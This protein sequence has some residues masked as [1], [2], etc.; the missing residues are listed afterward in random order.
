MT[1]HRTVGPRG[2]LGRALLAALLVAA[3]LQAATATSAAARDDAPVLTVDT[4]SYS[5]AEPTPGMP[6][7]Y[8]S[9]VGVGA[10]S[11][12]ENG[13]ANS[14]AVTLTHT[15][16]TGVKP[17]GGNGGPDWQCQAPSGQSITCATVGGSLTADT[18]LPTVAFSG[19][20]TGPGMTASIIQTS[21]S[22]AASSANA[23]P[24]TDTLMTAGTVPAAPS[25]VSTSA[26]G[27]PVDGG[28]PLTVRSDTD[29][30]PTILLIGTTAELAAGAPEFL[31]PCTSGPAAGCF[32]QQDDGSHIES[33]PARSTPGAVEVVVVTLGVGASTSYSYDAIPTP[34][35][36]DP[37]AAAT[38]AD[39]GPLS[40][41]SL[42]VGEEGVRYSITLPPPLGGSPLSWAVSG[43]TLP[44]GL[45]LSTSNGVLSGI[46]TTGGEYTFTVLTTDFGG[47]QET[48]EFGVTIAARPV[49]TFSA[50]DGQQGLNYSE[51]PSVEGGIAP[52][53]W[54][55]VAGALPGNLSVDS[56]TGLISGTPTVSGTFSATVAAVDAL[57]QRGTATFS[58]VIV[59]APMLTFGAPPS[60]RVA[61][62]YS[63]TLTATGT[64]PLVWSI[65]DGDLPAGLTLDAATGVLS[66]TP[67]ETGS[68]TFTVTVTDA[69]G[70]TA[71]KAA[72]LEIRPGALVITISADDT[73]QAL[74]IPGQ[75][76]TYTVLATNTGSVD[77]VG[78]T[79]TNDLRGVRDDANDNG[80][81][82][83]VYAGGATGNVAPASVGLA[84]TGDLPAGGSVRLTYSV[85]VKNPV[86][87]AARTCSMPSD[88]A[89]PAAIAR[90]SATTIR[91]ASPRCPSAAGAE[92][93]RDH[94]RHVRH[95]RRCCLVQN[96]GRRAERRLPRR[97]VLPRPG[98][99]DRRCGLQQRRHR[100]HRERVR[101]FRVSGL[102][103]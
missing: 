89:H 1:R 67:T 80:D 69:N 20:V 103:R 85:T 11:D 10:N 57:G 79:F 13:S 70:F 32:D 72:T 41:Q 16:P 56:A 28:D 39:V 12:S 76:V 59:P 18:T 75:T 77:L 62:A 52:F 53:E 74:T 26:S 24:A 87:R 29:V 91:A 46:P 34:S 15:M 63:T 83:A 96:R 2:R 61:V 49:V 17:L 66:G 33:M 36:D 95:S 44:P 88:P 25:A 90:R 43:G 27:G 64:G 22:T 37:T 8:T 35:A 58:L 98:R 100:H 60:G 84:W 92:P 4:I 73:A 68:S 94:R 48:T 101:H 51:Q 65:S 42:G 23:A 3:L 9:T 54:S 99:D 71:D 30:P 21:S 93:Y 31:L 55:I 50:A 97:G 86:T 38:P 45:H 14:A 19:I 81:V 40:V 78:A 102:D 7:S 47:Q 82:G 5:A 6:V